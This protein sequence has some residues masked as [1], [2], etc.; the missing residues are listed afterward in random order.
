MEN[1]NIEFSSRKLRGKI[2]EV[3]GSISNFSREMGITEVAMYKF[4]NG[5]A[6]WNRHKIVKASQLLHVEDPKEFNDLF[7]SFKSLVF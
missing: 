6:D 7:F 3:Y 5:K 4:L 2:V 1:N